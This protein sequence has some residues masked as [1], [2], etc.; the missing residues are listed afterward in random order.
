MTLALCACNLFTPPFALNNPYDPKN[1]WKH[2]AAL[3]TRYLS[4]NRGAG[5][6]TDIAVS[7]D[8]SFLLA[9]S[10]SHEGIWEIQ[11]GSKAVS[12]YGTGSGY[13]FQS[14]CISPAG[15]AAYGISGSNVYKLDRGAKK[16]TLIS[17]GLNAFNIAIDDNNVLFVAGNPGGL[18][19]ITRMDTSGHAQG[20]IS[21]SSLINV[22]GIAVSSTTLFCACSNFAGIL[23]LDKTT[24]SRQR[25]IYWDGAAWN[26]IVVGGSL[27]NGNSTPA[28]VAYDSVQ[29][30]L[31]AC[32]GNSNPTSVLDPANVAAPVELGIATNYSQTWASRVAV[33]DAGKIYVSDKS[34]SFINEISTANTTFYTSPARNGG[35]F[36]NISDAC[37]DGGTAYFADTLLWEVASLT[38]DGQFHLF[39]TPGNGIGQLFSPQ[40]VAAK[41]SDVYI[42]CT[43]AANKIV[44]YGVGGAF[45][46][47][48]PVAAGPPQRMVALPDGRLVVWTGGASLHSYNATSLAFLADTTIINPNVA[49]AQDLFFCI[50]TDGSKI[51]CAFYGSTY[52]SVGILS[53]DLSTYTEIWNATSDPAFT[54]PG[55]SGTPYRIA[56]I[57]P[58]P[59]GD[60]WVTFSAPGAIARITQTGS[61]FGSFAVR[62]DYSGDSWT[63]GKIVTYAL[64]SSGFW[65][66]PFANYTA[67]DQKQDVFV[68]YDGPFIGEYSPEAA[69]Q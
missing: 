4:D 40:S 61:V 32:F 8:G 34:F 42:G 29:A 9:V 16:I 62:T 56:G 51:Y 7:K 26:N 1:P 53:S 12:T 31:Y 21:D 60:V 35:E 36:G 17:S 10:D 38:S 68:A 24:G 6:F 20:T 46:A 58:A 41:G 57:A 28:D 55:L 19:T 45:I 13:Y 67:A 43:A 5:M 25:E 23:L 66:G 50:S 18:C 48:V 39:G 49:S 64:D 52:A 3:G 69:L 22:S 14:I 15:D 30:R 47:E 65:H 37:S 63:A 59:V 44:H 27:T 54:K 11:T 33:D 2:A